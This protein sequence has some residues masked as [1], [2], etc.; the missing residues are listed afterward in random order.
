MVDK[1]ERYRLEIPGLV[2]QAISLAEELGFP[3]MPEGRPAGS[4]GPPSAC[5]PEIGRLLSVLAAGFEA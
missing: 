1:F 5:I 3:L 2:Q 4:Q